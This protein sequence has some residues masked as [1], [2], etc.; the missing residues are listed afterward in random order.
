MRATE[1]AESVRARVRPQV[2]TEQDVLVT[3]L[4]SDGEHLVGHTKA[5]VQV[6]LPHA[7]RHMGCTLAV[8]VTEAAKFY[9]RADVLRVVHQ[10]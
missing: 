9:V 6:L 4:A 5:Y 2:G 7:P 1:I 8:R 10:P 3:E